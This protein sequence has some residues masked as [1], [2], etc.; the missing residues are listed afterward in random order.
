MSRPLSKTVTGSGLTTETT[1]NTYDEARAGFFNVGTLTT[2]TRIVPLNGSN[3]AVNNTK[4][5]NYDL[6]G[7]LA[8]QM[9]FDLAPNFYPV[10]SSLWRLIM[11]CLAVCAKAMGA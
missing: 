2:T 11:P 9:H 10:L 6:A 4:Q 5:F 8:Q 1:T 7:R 3:A